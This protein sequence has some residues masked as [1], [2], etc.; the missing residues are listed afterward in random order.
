MYPLIEAW[1][2]G[3]ENRQSFCQRHQLALSTFSYW[4]T[5]YRKTHRVSSGKPPGSFMAIQPEVPAFGEPLE[6]LYPNGVKLRVP[7]SGSLTM[8]RALIELM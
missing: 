5:H 4:L 8:L 6:I 3:E 1:E 2:C 7:A